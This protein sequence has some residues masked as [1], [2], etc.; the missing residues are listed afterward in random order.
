[1]ER[2]SYDLPVFELC[3]VDHL[4]LLQQL[5]PG[6]HMKCFC[7]WFQP[8]LCVVYAAVS[9]AVDSTAGKIIPEDLVANTDLV[10]PSTPT[11]GPFGAQPGPSRQ[12][13]VSIQEDPGVCWY[14]CV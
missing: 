9:A 1:M 13:E 7:N 2:A 12:Q 8:V 5:A 11:R 14:V 10:A 6:S 3:C 4:N